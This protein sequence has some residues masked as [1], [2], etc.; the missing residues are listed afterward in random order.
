MQCPSCTLGLPLP[1]AAISSS[2]GHLPES[3]RV[4][5][6]HHGPWCFHHYS[7]GQV[8]LQW[9]LHLS[10]QESARRPRH[11]WRD[12]IPRRHHGSVCLFSALLLY[13]MMWYD[14]HLFSEGL[15]SCVVPF[16]LLLRASPAGAGHRGWNRRRGHLTHPLR[17][18]QA[19]QE[20]ATETAGGERRVSPQREKRPIGVVRPGARGR[21]ADL[22]H[23]CTCRSSLQDLPLPASCLDPKPG[24]GDG[25]L[26]VSTNKR[27]RKQL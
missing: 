5:W 11:G 18:L 2:R 12:P 4:G 16:S 17:V 23:R 13:G 10:G 9:H 6:W 1:A 21:R 7:S 19:V 14:F 20:E 22:G 27:K 26:S 3:H 15:V 25:E 24:P 8:R